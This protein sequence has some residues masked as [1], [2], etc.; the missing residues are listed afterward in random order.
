MQTNYLKYFGGLEAVRRRFVELFRKKL[1][2]VILEEVKPLNLNEKDFTLRVDE[3]RT[4]I[5]EELGVPFTL[6]YG[7]GSVITRE[8]VDGCIDFLGC[9]LYTSPSPRD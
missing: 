3:V 8:L 2:E 7:D 9:L 6:L 4:R 5:M 1:T